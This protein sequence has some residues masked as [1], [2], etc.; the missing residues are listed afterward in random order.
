MRSL[1]VRASAL[2][3]THSSRASLN[4]GSSGASW[5]AEAIEV[6]RPRSDCL[7]PFAARAASRY[8]IQPVPGL[9]RQARVMTQVPESSTPAASGRARTA[10]VRVRLVRAPRPLRCAE[11]SMRAAPRAEVWCAVARPRETDRPEG[12]ASRVSEPLTTAASRP[13]TSTSSSSDI[14]PSMRD[15]T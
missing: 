2:A 8:P 9:G 6:Q 14:D 7:R 4:L 1:A 3:A 13:V 15:H 12:R 11:R 5:I 10:S